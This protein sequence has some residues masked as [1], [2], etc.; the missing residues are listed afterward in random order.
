MVTYTGRVFAGNRI[1]CLVAAFTI[2]QIKSITPEI[3]V[4]GIVYMFVCLQFV[5]VI[6]TTKQRRPVT[7]SYNI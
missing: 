4:C 6:L 3:F 5:A 1:V 7:N 2:T